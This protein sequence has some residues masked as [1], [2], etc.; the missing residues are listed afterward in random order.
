MRAY[1]IPRD[2]EFD[3][4]PDKGTCARYGLASRYGKLPGRNG[5]DIHTSVRSSNS[6]RTSR[7]YWKR[8]ER[9][10]AKRFIQEE[11]A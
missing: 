11:L 6:K 1:G 3:N 7:R 9:T 8:M 2:P 5:D 10:A 4:Y